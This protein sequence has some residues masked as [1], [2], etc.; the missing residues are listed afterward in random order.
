[1]YYLKQSACV[2][3]LVLFSLAISEAQEK[4]DTNIPRSSCSRDNA[5]NMIQRQIDLSKTIDGDAKRIVLL[6]RVAE[7]SWPHDQNR[8]RAAF[9][10]AFDI[11]ARLFKD[12]GAPD[13]KDGRLWVQGIDYRYTVIT[14]IA[15][16][17]PDW[18]RKLSQQILKEEADAAAAKVEDQAAKEKAERNP[19]GT[20]TS[21]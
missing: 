14:A 17:D 11:A 19:A 12:K 21:E 8:A 15:K 2:V 9:S 16:R 5:L 6:L 13:T 3:L 18:A 10:D 4:P 1:M 7:V 20:Q